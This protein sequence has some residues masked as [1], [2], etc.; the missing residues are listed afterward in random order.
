MNQLKRIMAAVDLS[1]YSPSVMEYAG[2]LCKK[3][4][5]E[6]VIVNVIN[7]RELDAIKTVQLFAQCKILEED[8]IKKQKAERTDKINMLVD[9][10]HLKELPSKIVFRVGIPFEQLIQAAK[11]ENVQMVVMGPKGRGNVPGVRFG[12]SAEKMFRH[13]PVPLLSVRGSLHGEESI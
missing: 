12:S 9:R 3:V 13:C 7:Q 1:D 8:V 10:Y 2:T 11:D 5:A 6:L 4:G